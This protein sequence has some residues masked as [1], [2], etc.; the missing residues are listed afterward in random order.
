[1]TV[2]VTVNVI[3]G[4]DPGAGGGLACLLGA[5]VVGAAYPM[6]SIRAEVL[7]ILSSWYDMAGGKILAVLEGVHGSPQM[8]VTS[9]TTFARGYGYLECALDAAAIPTTVVY[10][11][12]WQNALQCRTGGDKNVTKRAAM[13]LFPRV[14]VTHAIA[15]ALLLAEY[16]RR[17]QDDRWQKRKA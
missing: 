4:I 2:T 5:G 16:G 6:P 1:M 13:K 9:A 3:V 12:R 17:L 14:R 7:P 11:L 10:P 15:D 8:G